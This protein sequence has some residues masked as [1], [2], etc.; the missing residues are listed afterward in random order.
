MEQKK[1]AIVVANVFADAETTPVKSNDDAADDPAI[2]YNQEQP[3]NS[4]ILGT[5]KQRG[6]MVYQLNGAL[7]QEL[8]VGRVNNVD[9]R[10]GVQLQSAKH[11]IAVASNRTD[12]TLSVFAIANDGRV[13]LLGNHPLML[14]EPYGSCMYTDTSLRTYVFVNDKDGRYQQWW[15]ESIQPLK[16]SLVR[17]FATATQ[18]EGCAAHDKTGTLFIGEEGFGVWKLNLNDP[19]SKL[20]L[21][22]T[23]KDGVLVADVE[24]MDIFLG[25]NT[26][27]LIVSSQGDNSYAVYDIGSNADRFDYRGSFRT[28]LNEQTGVDG[29]QETDGLAV[30]SSGLGEKFPAGIIVIQD[31]FN[32][33]PK[34]AQNFKLLNW[35]SVDQAL[36]LG[37]DSP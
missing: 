15:L 21:L 19:E 30:S 1:N 22:T 28:I 27:Y 20:E 18:P 6:L 2:W 31:G 29:T 37:S 26:N 10:Q 32:R 36:S 5:D 34:Q 35:D 13:S 8:L 3:N 33:A 11:D 24:G 17:E 14:G 12:N 25:K 16:L 23:T 9:V 4:L 7:E